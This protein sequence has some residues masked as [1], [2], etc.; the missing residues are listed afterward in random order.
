VASADDPSR[1]EASDTAISS[2]AF[3]PAIGG[4]EQLTK[5]NARIAKD[6]AEAGKQ[7]FRD[8][9]E[10][11]ATGVAPDFSNIGA[12][13]YYTL[14]VRSKMDEICSQMRARMTGHL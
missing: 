6:D 12:L 14:Q 4:D 11:C 10:V 8:L 5:S 9:K 13:H 2:G 1:T 3:T 7:L